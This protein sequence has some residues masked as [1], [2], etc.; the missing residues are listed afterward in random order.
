[1][2]LLRQLPDIVRAPDVAALLLANL[3]PVVVSALDCLPVV[4][5]G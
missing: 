1:V 2:I 3:T 5:R 4:F